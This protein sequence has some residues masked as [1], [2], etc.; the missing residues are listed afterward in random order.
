MPVA[1]GQAA[2]A[3]DL[4]SPHGFLEEDL[5]AGVEAVTV[6]FNPA[7]ERVPVV[8]S[9]VLVGHGTASTAERSV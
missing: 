8:T 7:V 4:G 2:P 1:V 5:A 6:G 9:A 3:G